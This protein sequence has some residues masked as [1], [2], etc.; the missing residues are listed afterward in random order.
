MIARSSCTLLFVAVVAAS[1]ATPTATTAKPKPIAASYRRRPSEDHNKPGDKVPFDWLPAIVDPLGRAA[2][3]RPWSPTAVPQAAE[4]RADAGRARRAALA[5]LDD[6]LDD[7]RAERD[8]RRAVIATYARMERRSRARA[9][10]ARRPRRRSSTSAASCASS[11]TRAP[12]RSRRLTSLFER[13][14]FCHARDRQRHEGR[15]DRRARRRS[16][17]SCGRPRREAEA[18]RLVGQRTSPSPSSARSALAVALVMRPATEPG[19]GGIRPPRRRA[20]R[21]RCSPQ[22]RRPAV[23]RATD[24]AG[25][26]RCS[27]PR[28][29]ARRLPS[30]ER[31][32]R[33]LEMATQSAFDTHYRL[34]PLL[35]EL[36]QPGWPV[37]GV[38]LDGPG[39]RAEELLGPDAWALVRPG[40]R[41]PA[42]HHAAG[43][44]LATANRRRRGAG[45]VGVNADPELSLED[46]GRSSRRGSSTRSSAPSSAS[47]TRSSSSCSACSPT[48]TS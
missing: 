42:E 14:K 47:A 18:V 24:V 44:S 10:P 6:S 31:L 1:A 39:S 40:P 2:S 20:R 48:A 13:A 7:L 17:T 5:V 35:R 9:Y 21:G 26:T 19:G 29:K 30:L 43:A 45:T 46:V 36:A 33:E 28:R 16:A 25:S 4:A 34:R 12:T 8:P 37:A 32:E 11:C 27:R 15:R 38:D 22:R 23:R 41:R 3:A